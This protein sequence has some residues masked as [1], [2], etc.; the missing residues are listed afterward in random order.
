MSG[1]WRDQLQEF[2]KR[3]VVPF[4]CRILAAQQSWAFV[5]RFFL[6]YDVPEVESILTFAITVWFGSVSAEKEKQLNRIVRTGSKITGCVVPSISEIYRVRLK[7]KGLKTLKDSSHLSN[8]PFNFLPSQ[9]RLRSI[10]KRT[11]RFYNSMFLQRL[12]SSLTPPNYRFSRWWLMMEL[13][14]VLLIPLQV[15]LAV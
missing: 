9:K 11:T 7:E 12:S 15:F 1:K 4:W 2:Q 3:N 8:C 10:N 13:S 14:M 5:A 6:F